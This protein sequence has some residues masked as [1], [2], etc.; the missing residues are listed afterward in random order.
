MEKK[1]NK[2]IEIVIWVVFVL[3]LNIVSYFLETNGLNM[4]KWVSLA[5]RISTV[6]MDAFFVLYIRKLRV[7]YRKKF[8]ENFPKKTRTVFWLADTTTLFLVF[9]SLYAIKITLL[10]FIKAISFDIFLYALSGALVILVFFGRPTSW[11]IKKYTRSISVFIKK[12][13]L[14]K[15]L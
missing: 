3:I 4:P 11:I 9:Y 8:K 6:I 5:L 2:V 14:R 7:Y 12:L 13:I 1:L 10:F 15:R